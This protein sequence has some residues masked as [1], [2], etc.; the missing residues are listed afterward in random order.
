MGAR[1][2]AVASGDDG[3][4]LARRLGADAVANGRKDDVVAAARGFAP[5]GLDASLVT[6]GG[7]VADRTLGAVRDGGRIAYPNGVTPKPNARPGVRLNSY[8]AIRGQEAT[9]KL[10]R[11]ITSGAFEIH[12]AHT[13][14]LEQVAEAHRALEKHYL[15]KI[16]LATE[17]KMKHQGAL[18]FETLR[19]VLIEASLDCWHTLARAWHEPS[20]SVAPLTQPGLFNLCF[21]RLEL[22][23]CQYRTRQTRSAGAPHLIALCPA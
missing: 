14:P 2:L 13:F 12:V 10:H 22:G 4:A 3:V 16:A 21:P 5:D 6:A 8:D 23:G 18:R 17:W 9:A 15:G 19:D 11:L 1:V 7:A 20:S